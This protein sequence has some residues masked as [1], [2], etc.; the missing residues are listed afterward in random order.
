MLRAI[1]L[2]RGVHAEV[3]GD[4]GASTQA[5][6]AVLIVAVAVG[7]GAAL[8][9][10]RAGFGMLVAELIATVIGWWFSAY[11]IYVIGVRLFGG[12]RTWSRAAYRPCWPCSTKSRTTLPSSLRARSI[13]RWLA[14]SPSTWR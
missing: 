5:L 4:P 2:E 10:P 6:V 7:I 14:K 8:T 12:P 9:N 1:R 3:Q 11:L 13:R